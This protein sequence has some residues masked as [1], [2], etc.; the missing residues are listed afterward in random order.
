M[1]KRKY[2]LISKEDLI[3]VYFKGKHSFRETAIRLN[4]TVNTVFV[5]MIF[6]GLKS[7]TTSESGKLAWSE[8]RRTKVKGKTGGRVWSGSRVGV[9]NINYKDGRHCLVHPCPVCGKSMRGTIYKCCSRECGYKLR[10]SYKGEGNPN[11]LGAEHEYGIEFDNSLKERIRFRDGY[12]CKIC[13]CSQVENGRQLDIHHMDYNKKN[14]NVYNLISLCIHCH[15][16]TNSNRDMWK[17]KLTANG[18]QGFD[19]G[20]EISAK[21]DM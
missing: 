5:S 8:E 15:R 6:H 3:R 18:K 1:A 16:R 21:T 4:T 19:L 7:R 2:P 17:E 14:N 12:R 11:Y 10:R 20:R 9:M 13:G